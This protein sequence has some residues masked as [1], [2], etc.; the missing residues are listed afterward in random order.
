MGRVQ[1]RRKVR[2]TRSPKTGDQISASKNQDS[3]KNLRETES[4]TQDNQRAGVMRTLLGRINDLAHW[5]AFL[6][7][8][9][10]GF[11]F[12]FTGL[13]N[14]FQG[15]D[16]AQIVNNPTVHSLSHIGVFF[17]GSTFYGGESVDSP[18]IGVYYRPLMTVIFSLIYTFFHLNT[19]PYHFIQIMLCIGGAFL[20]YLVLRYSIGTLLSLA[21]ALVFLVHPINSQAAFAVPAMQDALYFFFGM[22]ALWLLMRF[23]SVRSL[24]FVALSLLL[25]VLSKEAGLMFFGI[26]LLYLGI[27]NRKRL[28]LLAGML[29]IPLVLWL[30]LN[31]NAVGLLAPTKVAPIDKLSLGGRLL[32]MPSIMSFYL[33]KLVFPRKLASGYYWVHASFSF[34][35]VL[36]P[37]LIDLAV[38]GLAVYLGR[39][40]RRRLSKAEYYAYLFFAA[41]AALGVF[42]ILQF[43][44]LD[45]TAC[46]TWFRFS[47][48]GIL[49][50]VGLVLLAYQE[51]VNPTWFFV[52]TLV[53]ISVFG[54]RTAVRG[55]DWSSSYKLTVRDIASS[56]EDYAAYNSEGSILMNAG[57]NNEALS[58]FRRSIAIYPY[59]ENYQNLGICEAK[60]GD[61]PAAFA[62]YERTLKYGY[63][64]AVFENMAELSLVYGTVQTGRQYILL[65]LREYPRDGLLWQYLA[66]LDEQHNDGADAKVAIS[67]A[68]RDGDPQLYSNVMSGQFFFLNLPD[69]GRNIVI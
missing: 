12:L 39:Q 4:I 8:L 15:D 52:T 28:G 3:E 50:M 49:G 54:V 11:A 46:E 38:I 68:A 44:T 24:W 27:F 69:L 60:I 29:T 65:G 31:V 45:L 42:T 26:S 53:L 33:F 34:S 43:S 66:L 7:L 63:D 18:L 59:V 36:L 64:S 19:F 61:Y 62:A 17:E 16:Q 23:K 37:L 56:K 47:S 30:V 14:P 20:L 40:V 48:V 22:L 58:D 35:N 55:T 10:L 32:T 9:V 13:N 2:K 5:Q 21:A 41:W 25:C 57:K 1:K 6:I 51:Y 67:N